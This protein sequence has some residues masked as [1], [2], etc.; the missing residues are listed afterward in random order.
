MQK[1]IKLFLTM[2]A[3]LT[4]G[5][6]M[7]SCGDETPEEPKVPV[8][9]TFAFKEA[10]YE[11]E[12]DE[13]LTVELD[14]E[15]AVKRENIVYTS[16]NP[17]VATFVA[18][19][20]KGV[21]VGETTIS[22]SYKDEVNDLTKS[23]TVKVTLSEEEQAYYD[24]AKA[25]DG[26]VEALSNFTSSDVEALKALVE[27]LDTMDMNVLKYV[28][29][30]DAV[31]DMYNKARALVIDE[32]IAAIPEV[33]EVSHQKQI[34]EAREAYKLAEANVKKHV[35]KEEELKAKES[36]LEKAI[37]DA[38]PDAVKLKYQ[39][40]SY[41]KINGNIVILAETAKKDPNSVLVWESSLYLVLIL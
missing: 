26:K 5:C 3:I 36:A 35:T 33:V 27:Q 28:T 30:G 13:R 4:L 15:E 10:S 25:Y 8:I 24:E 37:Y 7:A 29:K 38:T 9:N 40:E 14:L 17:E 1:S 18:G 19:V 22:I 39:E 21:S 41:T 20:L 2:I 34:K 32:L 12:L 11:I 6:F 16:A 23:V 31:I